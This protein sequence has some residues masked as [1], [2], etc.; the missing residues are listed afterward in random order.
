MRGVLYLLFFPMSLPAKLRSSGTFIVLLA[1][2]ATCVVLFAGCSRKEPP[3]PGTPGISAP[4][5]GSRTRA[6]LPTVT[7]ASGNTANAQSFTLLD[8]SK[9]KVTDYL[10][11]VL[12]LDFWATYCP[13]C[14]EET[15]HL[16]AL[17]QKY[18]PQG[19]EVVGLN[20]GG[21]DDRELIPEFMQKFGVSYKNGIPEQEM[22]GF[23]MQG[24]DRIPQTFLFDRNGKLLKHFVGFNDSIKAEMETTI[25]KALAE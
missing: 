5:T 8:D 24:D 10:G 16:Q 15:P 9:A 22:T 19:L 4:A 3:G 13:P 18:A 14:L 17:H 25:Q 23:Y 20:V 11:K 2:I 7:G 6:S 21:P 1:S 12:I